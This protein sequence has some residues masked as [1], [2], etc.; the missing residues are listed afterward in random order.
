MRTFDGLTLAQDAAF[1]RLALGQP[2]RCGKTTL[3]IL[4]KRGLIEAR[5]RELGG[6]PFAMLVTEYVVPISVHMRWCAW[7]AAN[8]SDKPSESPPSKENATP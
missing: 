2:P 7:C 5:Q 6:G 8:F 3:S 4:Q 1:S